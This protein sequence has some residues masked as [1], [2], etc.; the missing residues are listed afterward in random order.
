MSLILRGNDD[1][2]HV[3]CMLQEAVVP[4]TNKLGSNESPGVFAHGMPERC[5]D[6]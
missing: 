2:S 1:Y 6:T 5:D 4:T 3:T